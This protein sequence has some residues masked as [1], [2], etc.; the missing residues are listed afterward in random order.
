MAVKFSPAKLLVSAVIIAGAFIVGAKLTQKTNGQ[1]VNVKPAQLA[2]AALEGK[3]LFAANCQQCHG[4]NGAGSDSGPPLIHKIYHPGHHGDQSFVMA[5]RFGVR[6]HHWRFGNMPAQPQVSDT[7][8]VKII[9][10][11]RALQRANGVF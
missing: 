9:A 8:I 4:E 10:F 11:V 2:G 6:A 3:A 5:A 1:T 7:D